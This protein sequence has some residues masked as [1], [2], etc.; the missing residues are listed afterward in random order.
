V[1]SI[2]GDDHSAYHHGPGA[3]VTSTACTTILFVDY[4]NA[5]KVDL[6][7][8]PPAVFVPFFFGASQKSGL[9]SGHPSGGLP[10]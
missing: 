7:E 1:N 8:I 6:S 10:I 9:A 5:G 4:E 3:R 2:R